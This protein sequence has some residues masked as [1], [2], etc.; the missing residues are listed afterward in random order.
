[1]NTLPSFAL[2][3]AQGADGVEL[4]VRLTRDDEMMII[5]D[6]T[7]DHTTDGSG[8]INDMTFAQVRALDAG[9]WF[10]EKFRGTKIPTLDEVFQLIGGK[11]VINIEIKSESFRTDGVEAKVADAIRNHGL[12][13][14]VIVSSF[15]PL[16]LRRFYKIA[17]HIPIAYLHH[18]SVPMFFPDLMY[19]LPHNSRNPYQEDVTPRYMKW[20]KKH[21]YRVNT[22]TVNDPARARELRD[23]GVDCLITDNPDKIIAALRS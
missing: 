10:D 22:W 15:N 1:M 6:P 5:H 9:A 11:L 18:P 13:E 19:G 21:G 23:L 7:V 4:D 2:A 8:E 20:A 12:D 16:T 17:P 14:Q 3:L